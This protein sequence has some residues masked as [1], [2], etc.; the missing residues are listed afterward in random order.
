MKII[1]VGAGFTG[2]RLSRALLAAGRQVVVIDRNAERVRDVSAQLDCTVLHAEGNSLSVL[3]RAGL[4]SADA[5]VAVSSSD[6]VNVITC[7][8]ADA[9]HP[10]VLKIARVRNYEYYADALA[11]SGKREGAV[12]GRRPAFGIDWM[13]N[14]DA[15]AARVLSHTLMHGA[16]GDIQELGHGYGIVTLRVGGE[17]PILGRP[18]RALS[19]VPGWSFLIAY[20]ESAEGPHLPSGETVLKV[21]DRIGVLTKISEVDAVAAMCDSRADAAAKLLIAGSGRVGSLVVSSQRVRVGGSSFGRLLGWC[22]PGASRLDVTVVDEFADRC[23]AVSE[24]YRDVRVLCGDVMDA[25]VVAE[26]D[27]GRCDVALAVSENFERNLLAAA[28]LKSCGVVRTVA[29]TA[30]ADAAGMAASLGVDVAIPMDATIV[31]GIMSHLR[32]ANVLSV[33]TVCGGAYEIVECMVP[34]DAKA[35]GKP[36]K[37]LGLAGLALVLMVHGADGESGVP[38]G[39]TVIESG[40]TLVLI[41]PSGDRRIVSAFAGDGQ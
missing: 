9:V 27:L 7:A 15:E 40:S 3:E 16:V 38:R 29:L 26:E 30:S 23:Q 6:E 5:L 13:V 41:V 1:V 25:N 22:R 34:G 35:V 17:S 31:D 10:E 20:V 12:K 36:L 32:G 8:L 11:V 21:G 33:H 2:V 19:N 4:S 28:Y 18:L 14:P 37:E 24:H 39:D